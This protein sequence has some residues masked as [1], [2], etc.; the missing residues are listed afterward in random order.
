MG[1]SMVAGRV[2]ENLVGDVGGSGEVT[3][4]DLQLGELQ[5]G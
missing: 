5:T 2:G 3:F 4:E 1:L